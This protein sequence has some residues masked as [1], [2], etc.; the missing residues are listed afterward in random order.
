MGEHLFNIGKVLGKQSNYSGALTYFLQAYDNLPGDT[1]VL[2]ELIAAAGI[3]VDASNK[4]PPI[5]LKTL[6]LAS[7]DLYGEDRFETISIII[8]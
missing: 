8:V 6:L 3:A 7:F 4:L 1:I 5:A 2:K